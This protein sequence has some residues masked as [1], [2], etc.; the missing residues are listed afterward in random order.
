M[1]QTLLVI[2][3]Q[4]GV[5][6]GAHGRDQVVGNIGELVTAARDAQVPVVWVQHNEPAMTIGSDD[7]H[8]VDELDPADEP[9]VDKQY[10]SSFEDTSL[11][12]ILEN[13][14]T[15]ELIVCG[16]E[17]NYCVRHTIH[18]ALERGFDVTL[19]ADAHTTSDENAAQ[20]IAEQNDN[21]GNYRLPGRTCHTAQTAD[22]ISDW[23]TSTS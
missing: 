8:L 10:R 7:W 11:P 3:V 12:G 16:A 2:D 20:V 18:S 17:T 1:T 9:R 19:V 13:L 4:H 22:V 23:H 6:D 21:F 14:A 5:I 15:R